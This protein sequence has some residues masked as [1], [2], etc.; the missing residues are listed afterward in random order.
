MMRIIAIS[1]V[2]KME[3][4]RKRRV[5]IVDDEDHIVQMLDINMRTQGYESICVNSGEQALDAAAKLHPDI[6]LLDVMMPEMDGL[7]VCR[8]LKADPETRSIPVI[9]VSAKSEERDKIAG[10]MGGADDYI[11]KPFNLQELFLRIKAA[12][13]Q[14]DILSRAQGVHY[15]IGS[16]TLDTQKYQV[17]A[18]GDRIDLTLTE[19]RILHMLFQ[20]AGSVVSREALIREVFEKDPAE[21]GRTVDVHVRNIRKKLDSAQAKACRIDTIRGIGYMIKDESLR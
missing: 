8:R 5:L 19:F 12:L 4:I 7:E 21:M 10:L 11:T 16:V 18:S 20:N 13:R 15:E 3:E 9:M 1:G 2:L 14:V 17:T 6:I